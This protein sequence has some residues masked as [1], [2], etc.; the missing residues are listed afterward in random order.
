MCTWTVPHLLN[1]PII[2]IIIIISFPP[3]A[4][5]CHLA[6]SDRRPASIPTPAF[7][8]TREQLVIAGTGILMLSIFK[9]IFGLIA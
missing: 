3:C 9:S 1:A 8:G 2:I 6:C 5:A 7:A 4:R